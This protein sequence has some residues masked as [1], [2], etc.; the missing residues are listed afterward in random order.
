MD[1]VIVAPVR[2]DARHGRLNDDRAAVVLT[3]RTPSLRSRALLAKDDRGELAGS[4][5]CHREWVEAVLGREKLLGAF[6]PVQKGVSNRAVIN[7]KKARRC[8]QLLCFVGNAD[9]QFVAHGSAV[10]ARR[11]PA[12]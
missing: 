8:G 10:T 1:A 9:Y 3:P 7:Q 11:D 4:P 12:L 2:R 5:I 6:E